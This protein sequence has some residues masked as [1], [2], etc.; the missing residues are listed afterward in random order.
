MSTQPYKPQSLSTKSPSVRLVALIL[1]ATAGVAVA[2]GPCQA[3]DY[4]SA[5][6]IATIT[7]GA[8]VLVYAPVSPQQVLICWFATTPLVSYYLKFPVDRS[9]FT[10]DRVIIASLVF[11]L[12]LSWSSVA[13]RL[14]QE[15]EEAPA[16]HYSFSMTRFELAWALLA[17]LALGSV[18][19]RAGNVAYATRLAVDTFVLPLVAF[20]IARNY[21]DLQR[22]GRRIL[23]ACIAVAVFLFVT[24]TFELA[25]G[26]DLF[27][28]KGAH[29]VR[30]GERR[31]N[32]P[33]STDTSFAVICLMLFLFLLAAPRMFRVRLDRVARLVYAIALAA[34]A[35]GALLPLFRTVA[36]ALIVCGS[37]LA[38]STRAGSV[39]RKRSLY[40]GVL[41]AAV[42]LVAVGLSSAIAPSNTG[43]RLTNPR[44]AFGRLATWQAAAEIT[45]DNPVFGAG[46]GNYAEYFDAVHYYA[47]EPPEEVLATRAVDSPHSN[48]LWISSELG[49]TG[50]ALY[51]TAS[52]CLL[53]MSWRAFRNAEDRFQRGAAAC[54]LALIFAYWIPGMT[55]TSG[56]YSDLNLC[57]F[58]LA[59]AL[60]S[61]FVRPLSNRRSNANLAASG[62]AD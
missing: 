26:I 15:A 46:L 6:V 36:V 33:F 31:V 13:R 43:R 7:V 25:T 18:V 11:A 29:F 57:F 30:E 42:L 58:F 20:H 56:Y 1:V 49:L 51:I 10:Y 37:F 8:G 59:G 39:A 19:T 60:S 16:R 52:V 24:G 55:L 61:S 21:F 14:D 34:A 41:A 22:S 48:P 47:D 12:L 4:R 53:L 62:F 45:L 44:S 54:S 9:I 40:V 28:I 17:L 38:W 27:A 3:G 32:G 23:L 2:A 50:L 5:L 35:L